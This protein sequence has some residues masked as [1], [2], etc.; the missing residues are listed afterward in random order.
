MCDIV[1]RA[2]RARSSGS[3]GQ[4]TGVDAPIG[5]ASRPP[6]QPR[7]RQTYRLVNEDSDDDVPSSPLAA[8]MPSDGPP[9]VAA[10]DTMDHL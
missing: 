3:R 1:F 10:A 4:P 9:D 7:R 5:E 8:A 6:R 2:S